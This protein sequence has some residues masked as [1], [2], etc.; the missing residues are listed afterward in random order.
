MFYAKVTIARELPRVHDLTF[1]NPFLVGGYI[2]TYY[3]LPKLQVHSTRPRVYEYFFCVQ[4]LFFL[5]F[6]NDFFLLVP[7]HRYIVV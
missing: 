5:I 3:Q 1:K 2:N 7:V 6:R 4:Y